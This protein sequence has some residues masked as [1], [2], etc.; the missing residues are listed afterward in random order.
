MMVF[1]KKV[2]NF[3]CQNCDAD[4]VG[5]GYTNHCPRCLWSKHADVD[6]GDR[7]ADCD[8]MMKP[9]GLEKRGEIFMIVLVCQ[10]CGFKRLNKAEKGDN[11]E[12]LIKIS[13]ERL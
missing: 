5:S 9:S 1:K 10:K 4:V 11:F 8:G 2:E 6:P 13:S 3:R 12:E 7:L